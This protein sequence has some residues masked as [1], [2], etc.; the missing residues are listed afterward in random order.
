MSRKRY[1][2]SR[3]VETDEGAITTTI[4]APTREDALIMLQV[5]RMQDAGIVVSDALA[6]WAVPQP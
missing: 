5:A 1:I 6:R 4:E 2:S 3:T